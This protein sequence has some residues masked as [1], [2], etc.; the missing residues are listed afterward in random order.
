MEDIGISLWCEAQ[1]ENRNGCNPTFRTI[2][3]NNLEA[4]L[5]EDKVNITIYDYNFRWFFNI[6]IMEIVYFVA[7]RPAAK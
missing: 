3:C 6:L 5:F 2:S 4:A 7:C 1:N